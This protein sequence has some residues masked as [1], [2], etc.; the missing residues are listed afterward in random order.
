M[1]QFQGGSLAGFAAA[2]MV[3]AFPLVATLWD[4]FL[5]DEFAS[6]TWNV[7]SSL[8]AMYATYMGGIYLLAGSI[9]K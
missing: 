6:A 3:Q 1:L 2:D 9:A 7:L 8:A 5:F 4:I